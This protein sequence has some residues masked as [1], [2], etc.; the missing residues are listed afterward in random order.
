MAA[1]WRGSRTALVVDETA[2]GPR[3]GDVILKVDLA[4][5]APL[6]AE[7]HASASAAAVGKGHAL[8]DVR[9]LRV[10]VEAEAHCLLA[11][12][13]PFRCAGLACAIKRA[14]FTSSMAR[15]GCHTGP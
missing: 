6:E 7:L 9:G 12:L 10:V 4:A 2:A 5:L 8:A 3:V 1:H 15:L 13:H 11:D 14:A